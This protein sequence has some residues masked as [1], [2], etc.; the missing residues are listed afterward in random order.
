MLGLLHPVD[1]R[2][3]LIQSFLWEFLQYN[4]SKSY[5]I[6]PSAVS[7][8]PSYS[9]VFTSS[10]SSSIPLLSH[11]LFIF[12]SIYSLYSTVFISHFFL[13]FF[14]YFS[15]YISFSFLFISSPLS[16]FVSLSLSLSE[17][18]SSS[19]LL[20]FTLFIPLF[21]LQMVSLTSL[22][23]TP[24]LSRSYFSNFPFPSLILFPHLAIIFRSF[25]Y[26]FFSSFFLL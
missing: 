19:Y 16:R 1:G 15:L 22:F 23:L 9:M 12:L 26:L 11:F 5:V 2:I 20:L 8:P 14:H 6:P 10:L 3:F 18:Y 21:V 25:H 24:S 17:V 4:E 13:C 7:L